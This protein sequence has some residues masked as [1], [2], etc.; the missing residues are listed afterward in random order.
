MFD[1]TPTQD[2]GVYWEGYEDQLDEDELENLRS[3]GDRGRD[4]ALWLIS[5][6]PFMR[7][8][9]SFG[10]QK[11]AQMKCLDIL[12]EEETE[13]QDVMYDSGEYVIAII[14]VFCRMWLPQVEFVSLKGP[15]VIDK[16]M[17]G[18]DDED[19]NK[20]EDDEDDEIHKGYE[21]RKQSEDEKWPEN[22]KEAYM[23]KE[24]LETIL[25]RPNEIPGRKGYYQEL[26]RVIEQFVDACPS[27]KMLTL[28]DWGRR[29]HSGWWRE[30][31]SRDGL[32][33]DVQNGFSERGS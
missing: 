6:D 32:Q 24:L 5:K 9:R 22:S 16:D 11:A 13:F 2:Q 14:G 1:E 15:F 7:Q 33:V 26:R 23:G 3:L 29:G 10:R 21:E 30:V 17:M 20:D 19:D 28:V 27:L 18:S 25:P 8:L 31:A 4:I 12:W